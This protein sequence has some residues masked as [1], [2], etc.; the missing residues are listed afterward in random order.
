MSGCFTQPPP[1]HSRRSDAAAQR[2]IT[3]GRLGFLQQ[4][5]SVAEAVAAYT[6][7]P[8]QLTGQGAQQGSL[9]AGKLADLV[10]LDR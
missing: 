7:G 3:T 2:W 6:S 10:G 8:A 5:L 9:A 4:R 1:G